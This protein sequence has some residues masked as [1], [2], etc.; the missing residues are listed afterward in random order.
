MKITKRQLRRIIKE[1]QKK[2]VSEQPISAEQGRQMQLDQEYRLVE[3]DLLSILASMNAMNRN[4][5]IY[6]LID[7]LEDMANTGA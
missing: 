6:S 7:S 1:E 5:I 3:K 4:P 2:I